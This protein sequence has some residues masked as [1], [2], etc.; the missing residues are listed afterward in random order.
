LLNRHIFKLN[1]PQ[2]IIA[3]FLMAILAGSILLSLPVATYGGIKPVDAIFTATS[4]TC[5]TGLIVKDTGSFF[6]PFGQMVI[7]SLI[8]LGGL[9]IMTFSTAFAILLGRKLTIKDTLVVKSALDQSHVEN[10]RGL[11]KYILILTITIEAIGVALLYFK[12]SNVMP[13]SSL[14][15]LYHSVFHSV[16]AFCNA[17]FSLYKDSFARF[18]SDV[19][20]NMV[21]TGLIIIGGLGF[22]VL[23]DLRNLK[24]LKRGIH[25][26]SSRLSLQTKLALVISFSL[27]ILAFIGIYALENT[28]TLSGMSVKE[29]IASCYFQSITPRTAGFNTL[30]ISEFRPRTLFFMLIFM[31]IGASP[32]ST[33]GGIKTVTIGVL[34]AA[35]FAMLRHR[36]RVSMFRKSIP[37]DIFR[38][39]FI[40]LLLSVAW[41]FT[42]TLLLCVTESGNVSSG[43]FLIKNLFE[44]VSAFGTVG[45]STGITSGLSS[46]G[47]L[48]IT[49]TM[50]VGRIGP[51]TLAMA[52]AASGEK[53]VNFI[54]PEERIMV[55]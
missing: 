5:V 45:L 29:K 27:I 44:V 25:A 31:F 21:M 16:S 33:G 55:G 46:L 51:L 34:L 15:V 22:L 47:K 30:P 48:L 54:Y 26:F 3:S 7:L 38:R 4:A 2:A 18:R 32:G 12:W 49:I 52:V 11:I 39:A 43:N 9:G 6:T 28:N 53:K 36:S 41:I 20:I 42:S 50:F 8:Q 23:L 14:E 17:G 19:Y 35:V 1:P 24:F 10:L 13:G 40:I 37:R